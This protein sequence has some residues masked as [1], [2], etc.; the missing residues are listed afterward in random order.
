M[1][2]LVELMRL[3][4]FLF[5]CFFTTF[6][7]S[8][9]VVIRHGWHLLWH[10]NVLKFHDWVY[11]TAWYRRFSLYLHHHSPAEYKMNQGSSPRLSCISGMFSY[12]ALMTGSDK[13]VYTLLW[14]LPASSPALAATVL[15]SFV[16]LYESLHSLFLMRDA[17]IFS[18]YAFSQFS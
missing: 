9:T 7:G 10:T 11:H 3:I 4:C 12:S 8:L 16:W 5:I 17:D 2:S 15:V 13:P 6:S 1:D 14:S 18:L